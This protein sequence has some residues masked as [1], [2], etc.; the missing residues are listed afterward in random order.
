MLYGLFRDK[1]GVA[2]RSNVLLNEEGRVVLV[3]VY[4]P[5]QLPDIIE[6]IE[7]IKRL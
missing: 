2:E 1:Y 3:K 5:G 6:I 7:A 4:E